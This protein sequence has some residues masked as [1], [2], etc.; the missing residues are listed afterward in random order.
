MNSLPNNMPPLP[1]VNHESGVQHV[2]SSGEEASLELDEASFVPDEAYLKDHPRLGYKLKP[3]NELSE[4]ARASAEGFLQEDLSVSETGPGS[5]RASSSGKDFPALQAV[6]HNT[7][8]ADNPPQEVKP[9]VVKT[10][11]EQI[12]EIRAS[13]LEEIPLPPDFTPEMYKRMQAHALSK[14][15]DSM[16]AQAKRKSGL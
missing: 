5:D 13:I 4:E 6:L 9:R 14:K 3:E 7:Y 15:L 10:R 8:G 11:D 2:T 12:A 16:D 1:K